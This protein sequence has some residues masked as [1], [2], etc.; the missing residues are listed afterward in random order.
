MDTA[1]EEHKLWRQRFTK[2]G[3]GGFDISKIKVGACRYKKGPG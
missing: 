1:P 3:E 2:K